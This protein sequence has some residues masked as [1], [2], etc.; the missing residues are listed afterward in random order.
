LWLERYSYN[1]YNLWLE[2]FMFSALFD[3]DTGETLGQCPKLSVWSDVPELI[4]YKVLQYL[5]V[6]SLVQLDSASCNHKIRTDLKLLYKGLQSSAFQQKHIYNSTESIL[7]VVSREIE[8]P[9]EFLCPLPLTLKTPPFHWFCALQLLKL[10]QRMIDE[11]DIDVNEFAYSPQHG[12]YNPLMVAVEHA[13]L[14]LLNLLLSHKLIHV[15]TA[16]PVLKRTALHYASTFGACDAMKVLLASGA[17]INAVD[18][19]GY[20]PLNLLLAVNHVKTHQET[21]AAAETLLNAGANLYIKSNS[22]MRPIDFATNPLFPHRPLLALLSK[23]DPNA[24]KSEPHLLQ[25]WPLNGKQ[26][27]FLILMSIAGLYVGE[28]VLHVL[29]LLFVNCLM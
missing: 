22:G 26:A 23:H 20:T 28:R 10:V 3:E 14:K 27:M 16:D 24:K 17:N 19:D 12:F 21:L 8:V 4:R 6:S 5:D 13:D 15:N 7:W 25:D 1:A 2:V 11:E 18:I 9:L 29:V